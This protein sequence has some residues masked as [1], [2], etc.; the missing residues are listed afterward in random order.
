[1]G[2]GLSFPVRYGSQ[3]RYMREPE[4]ASRYRNRFVAAETQVHRLE[5]IIDEEQSNLDDSHPWLYVSI[6]PNS[7]REAEVSL[8]TTK[9]TTDWLRQE[10]WTRPSGGERLFTDANEVGVR[11]VISAP[12]RDQGGLVRGVYAEFHADGSS[13]AAAQLGQRDTNEI[14]DPV[15]CWV[16]LETALVELVVY[17]TAMISQHAI[18]RGC[19]GDGVAELGIVAGASGPT[20]RNPMVLTN[21]RFHGVMQ[22]VEFRTLAV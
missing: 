5:T 22:N 16:L 14:G 2:V 1:M 19:L 4:I 9:E 7:P 13:F 17:L 3:T 8:G 6:V 15:N 11:R 10:V 12:V 18:R 20:L 21:D